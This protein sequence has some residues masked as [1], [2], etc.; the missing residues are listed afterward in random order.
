MKVTDGVRRILTC[1]NSFEA[2]LAFFR[3]VIGLPVLEEGTPVTDTQFRRYATLGMPN[4]VVLE[5]VEPQESVGEL[6][7]GPVVSI[8]VDDV[9]QARSDLEAKGVECVAPLFE[10]G[11]GWGWTYFRAPDGSVYQIQGPCVTLDRPR[12]D[13]AMSGT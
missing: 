3:D 6:Y 11:S 2:T 4:G 7:T 12:A 13:R 8:T 10:T 5:V 9:V 1:T